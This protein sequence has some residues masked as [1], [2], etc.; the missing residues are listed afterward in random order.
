MHR[1]KGNCCVWNGIRKKIS[2]RNRTGRGL[3]PLEFVPSKKLK[4]I[5]HTCVRRAFANLFHVTPKIV[6]HHETPF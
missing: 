1:L 6:F 2:V 5:A 4:T 3:A